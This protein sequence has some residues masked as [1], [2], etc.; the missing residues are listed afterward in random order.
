VII[1]V[2]A[3]RNTLINLGR[4]AQYSGRSKGDTLQKVIEK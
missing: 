1:H 4:A 2:N 3:N